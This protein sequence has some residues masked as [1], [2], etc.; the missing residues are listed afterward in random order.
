[1]ALVTRS[2]FFRRVD[3]LSLSQSSIR[4]FITP[5]CYSVLLYKMFEEYISSTLEI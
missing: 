3:T 2:F 5:W 1:M 4:L